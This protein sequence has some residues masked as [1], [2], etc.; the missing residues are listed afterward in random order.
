MLKEQG[1]EEI[2]EKLYQ[3]LVDNF[4]PKLEFKIKELLKNILPEPKSRWLIN[5]W[6]LGH[7]D[8]SVYRHGEL[9]CIVEPGGWFHAKD[10]NQR[11]NDL[12]KNV[13]CKNNKVNCLR[14]FNDVV[15]DNLES[16]KTRRLFKK[17][18]YGKNLK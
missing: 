10:T 16:F 12:K 4:N 5:I 18:F 8:V 13:L 15:E 3:Y 14:F 17:Y 11:I 1:D 7:A 2:L 9:V 6:R